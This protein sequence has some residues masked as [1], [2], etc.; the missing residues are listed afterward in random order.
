MELS[1]IP[2][3][4][5]LDITVLSNDRNKEVLPTPPSHP[6]LPVGQE[7]QVII[8]TRKKD[9]TDSVYVEESPQGRLRV[10]KR[11]AW[12]NKPRSHLNSELAIMEALSRLA[13]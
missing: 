11:V 3:L 2:E 12:E 13:T 6:E 10:V 7:K 1:Q 9:L 5:K 8:W 4:F